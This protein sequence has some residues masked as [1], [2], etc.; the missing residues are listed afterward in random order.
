M[1]ISRSS[2]L[3]INALLIFD[4]HDLNGALFSNTTFFCALSFSFAGS[5]KR[6]I[7][8]FTALILSFL[9]YTHYYSHTNLIL[10]KEF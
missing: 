10:T 4:M 6:S 9:Q 2:A 7:V 8:L 5:A 3:S 1:T